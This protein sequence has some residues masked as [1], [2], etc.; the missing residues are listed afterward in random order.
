M[1]FRELPG[2]PAN[3]PDTSKLDLHM[4][5]APFPS[6]WD[7]ANAWRRLRLEAKAAGNYHLP[8]SMYIGQTHRDPLLESLL[9]A[10]LYIKAVSILDDS[11][12]NWLSQNQHSLKSPYRSDLN[13]RLEYLRDKGLLK[14]VGP[15]HDIRKRRNTLAHTPAAACSWGELDRDM[16]AIEECLV[17]LGLAKATGSL[18]YFSER[19]ALGSSKEPGI[20]FTRT[21]KY[22][23]HQNG[24]S[25][26]EISWV[27]NFHEDLPSSGAS[28]A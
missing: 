5:V 7:T 9:P 15:L 11:L 18:E 1:L 2:Y 17:S 24:K 8:Y 26:L 21:F 3:S 23:V 4:N 13:G 19:S 27:Q 10:L 22:G 12:D 16:Q 6:S 14:Q 20:E 28:E 25:A